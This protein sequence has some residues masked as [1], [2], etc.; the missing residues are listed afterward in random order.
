MSSLGMSG[1]LIPAVSSS[2]FVKAQFTQNAFTR[3]KINADFSGI[4]TGVFTDCRSGL[5][6]LDS[7]KKGRFT[8]PSVFHF[9]SRHE[10]E[11]RPSPSRDSTVGI[12]YMDEIG[13]ATL[14][15]TYLPGHH[16]RIEIFGRPRGL[17]LVK[18]LLH[19][20]WASRIQTLSEV[21]VSKKA[22]P[23]FVI[24]QILWLRHV[25]DE[26]AGTVARPEVEASE[27]LRKLRKSEF[28]SHQ[29][30][31]QNAKTLFGTTSK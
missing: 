1:G 16:F 27:A 24:S 31:L 30:L 29:V 10:I 20:Q 19:Q 14:C 9:D 12:F 5:G 18:I 25:I 17:F 21:L 22:L 3:H 11:I 2:T 6:I 23:M 7:R 4:T 28:L 26:T 15:E 8:M 13:I